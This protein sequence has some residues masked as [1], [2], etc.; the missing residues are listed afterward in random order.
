MYAYVQLT[1][2]LLMQLMAFHNDE[3]VLCAN[4]D[5]LH[6]PLMLCTFLVIVCMLLHSLRHVSHKVS[7]LKVLLSKMFHQTLIS[8]CPVVHVYVLIIPLKPEDNRILVLNVYPAQAS[9]I[10]CQVM[11]IHT[12]YNIWFELDYNCDSHLPGVFSCFSFLSPS[13]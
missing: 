5:F 4:L 10:L 1:Q 6:S 9:A 12:V 2:M 3:Y 11:R 13:M 8:V 7:S